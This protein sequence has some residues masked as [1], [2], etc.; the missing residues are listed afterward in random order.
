MNRVEI[1]PER[2]I[3]WFNKYG[4]SVYFMPGTVLGTRDNQ[5]T[6]K[7]NRCPW[8]VYNLERAII[9]Y[10][11]RRANIPWWSNLVHVNEPPTDNSTVTAQL[12]VQLQLFCP[13]KNIIEKLPFYAREEAQVFN[14]FLAVYKESR[15]LNYTVKSP[16]E[17]RLFAMEVTG[18]HRL[19]EHGVNNQ[20]PCFSHH[21]QLRAVGY[22][23][24]PTQLAKLVYAWNRN[25]WRSRSD[26]EYQLIL[27]WV[28]SSW[29][30]T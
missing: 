18:H 23:V 25:H 5:W 9:I 27:I 10:N 11:C 4:V 1:F 28:S 19:G 20:R 17:E 26:H 8:G 15:M 12:N 16:K 7:K 24:W 3:Q 30:S 22:F 29:A 14:R 13:L 21:P 2:F 6:K